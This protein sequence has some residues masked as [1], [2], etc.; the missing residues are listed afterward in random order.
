[1][2]VEQPL[3]YEV[4]DGIA[5][6]TLNRPDKL[7]ALDGDLADA[8]TAAWERFDRDDEA[9]VAILAGEGKSFCAGF[10]LRPNSITRNGPFVGLQIHESWM[11]NGVT[12]F[13]PRIAMVQ[14]YALGAGY[15][16]AVRGCDI[17]VA[18][19]SALFGF[20]EGKAGIAAPPLDHTPVM[21]LKAHLEM[22]LL[23]YKGGS[24][25][26]ADRAYQL[27]VINEVVEDE[28]DLVDAAKAWAEKLKQV[29]PLFVKSIKY[30]IY[31]SFET[32]FERVER[33]YL[34]FVLPQE[35]S[36]DLREA[37]RAFAD[38]RA[39]RFEGR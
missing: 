39:P 26:S 35:E 5:F 7:N 31:K 32:T 28:S 29:P 4:R 13:K 9:Q 10:D 23:G 25:M 24:L 20:P 21:P 15:Y 17:V 18:A 34:N 11:T 1:M 6:L 12:S 14:G 3:R 36:E 27:G 2:P 8:I 37:A 16:L 38:K 33:E 19:R 30:G 22:L